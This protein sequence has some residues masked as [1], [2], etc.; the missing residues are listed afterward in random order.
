[1]SAGQQ[2]RYTLAARIMNY[3]A[4]E[5]SEEGFD[6]VDVRVFQGGGRQ[7]V[8]LYVDRPGE[9][10]IDLEGCAEASRSA[11]L[12]LDAVDDF[13][14]PWVL[15]VSSPGINPPLRREAHFIEAIGCVIRLKWLAPEDPARRPLNLR[16]RLLDVVD[17]MLSIAPNAKQDGPDLER[18]D[19]AASVMDPVSVPISR[20]LEANLDQEFDVQAAIRQDRQR[21]KQAKSAERGARRRRAAEASRKAHRPVADEPDD[22]GTDPSDSSELDVRDDRE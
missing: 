9:G 20:V 19:T 6:L 7:Q 3:L 10:R 21:R 4:P 15:E 1:V 16:G 18:D 12:L 14:G 13:S 5:L 8:R 2:E 11:S 17:G 22:V